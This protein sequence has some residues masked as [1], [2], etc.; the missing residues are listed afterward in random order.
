MG[1]LIADPDHDTGEY[2]VLV[3]DAFQNRGLGSVLTDTCLEL[4]RSWGLRRV[5]AQT[6]SDNARMIAVF[7]ERGFEVTPEEE[8]LV[9][10]A[11]LL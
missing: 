8:G 11:K 10:V 1:R 7:Q 4:A 2:A 9:T 5:V 6:T 3:T